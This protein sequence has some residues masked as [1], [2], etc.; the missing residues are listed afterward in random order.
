MK[1]SKSYPVRAFTL[2]EMLVVVAIIGILIAVLL[3]A[4]GVI[5]TS[6]KKAQGE[7]L[8]NT[9]RTGIQMFQTEQSL[10]SIPPSVSD[11]GGK[12]ATRDIIKNPRKNQTGEQNNGG[13]DEVRVTGAQLLVHAMIGADGLGTAGFRDLSRNGVWWDDYSD[14][15]CE[16]TT[17]GGLYGLDE[18][19]QPCQPRYGGAG[20]VD[21]KARS[22]LKSARELIET[23]VIFTPESEI[24]FALDE[25]MFMDPF[26]TP[27]L[28]YRANRSA[29]R[30]VGNA[31]RSGI[32]W[33]EDNGLITGVSQGLFS[34]EGVDFGA[35]KVDGAYHDMSVAWQ[36]EP[37][38]DFD[39]LQEECTTDPNNKSFF[40]AIW[41]KAVRVRPTPV[42]TDSY[43]LISAGPD[44]RYGTDDDIINWTKSEG[45]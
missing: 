10:G 36:P 25:P 33:Q 4:F 30:A 37:T 5:R 43:L 35:G 8:F 39:Q 2:V 9:L 1:R 16:G 18:E 12:N 24:Q 45:E 31:Q 14:E 20:Y 27:I 38:Q 15:A 40:C 29:P 34:S 17:T 3:P 11:H 22:N 28:Y 23:G 26:N 32:F 19:A 6:A 41:D 13:Q 7:A 42:N 44:T 21:E